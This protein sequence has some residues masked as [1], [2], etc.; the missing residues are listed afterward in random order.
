MATVRHLWNKAVKR[1]RSILEAL[2]EDGSIDME[3]LKEICLGC[4]AKLMKRHAKEICKWFD[5]CWKFYNKFVPLVL[6]NLSP[7]QIFYKEVDGKIK[8]EFRKQKMILNECRLSEL[9]WMA[10]EMLMKNSKPVSQSLSEV[11]SNYYY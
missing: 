8:I 6:S 10:P 7:A 1:P 3:L 2:N 9:M 11:F 5:N 4:L